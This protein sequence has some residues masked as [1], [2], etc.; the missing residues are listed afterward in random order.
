MAS[1]SPVA[2]LRVFSLNPDAS[3]R[4]KQLALPAGPPQWTRQNWVAAKYH[5]AP[6]KRNEYFQ[7]RALGR[8]HAE[9]WKERGRIWIE[10]VKSSD[11]GFTNGE[12]PILEG[13]ESEPNEL[14]SND[15]LVRLSPFFPFLFVL[16][17]FILYFIRISEARERIRRRHHRKRQQNRPPPQSRRAPCV[18]LSLLALTLVFVFYLLFVAFCID[19]SKWVL[20]LTP[21]T[22]S[23]GEPIR[24]QLRDRVDS[25][26]LYRISTAVVS[27][28]CP[29]I[30]PA[31]RAREEP[32]DMLTRGT[33]VPT[34]PT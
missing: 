22:E 25:L 10:D 6:W 17:C 1:C 24:H 15:I 29:S 18:C 7:S 5:D 20:V 33:E 31:S 11:G 14:K 27:M 4:P 9:V 32:R 19:F 16:P 13:R 21:R 8:Q 2:I 3:S 23:P 30:T 26:L 34:S 12:R 28:S